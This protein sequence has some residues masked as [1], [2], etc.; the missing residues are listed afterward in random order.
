MKKLAGRSC[1]GHEHGLRKISRDEDAC[2]NMSW[3]LRS[4]SEGCHGEVHPGQAETVPGDLV[5]MIF[6]AKNQSPG[7]QMMKN[8]KVNGPRFVTAA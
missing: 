7:K 5:V 1:P 4:E 8:L 2:S 6:G 3:S